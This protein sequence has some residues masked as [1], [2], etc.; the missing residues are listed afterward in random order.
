VVAHS[1]RNGFDQ[2]R[3]LL[4]D[5]D[6][7]CSFG[8]AVDSKYVIAIDTDG[9]HTIRDTS[10]RDAVTSILVINGCRDGIHVVPAIEQRLA[11]QR[12]CEVQGSMEV[13]LRSTP[14]TK[15]GNC[16][17]VLIIDAELVASTCGLR[18]LGA[19]GG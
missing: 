16:D 4:L 11:S 7:A 18:H 6:L 10:D 3:S 2:D 9:R 5:N 8:G 12:R 1:V 19:E 17:S 13:T 14:V 15:V